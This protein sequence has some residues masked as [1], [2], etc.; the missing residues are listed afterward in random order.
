MWNCHWKI[1]ISLY[2]IISMAIEKL[3]EF[4]GGGSLEQLEKEVKELAREA[5]ELEEREN[6]ERQEGRLEEAQVTKRQRELK[7]QEQRQRLQ[8]IKHIRDRQL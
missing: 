6:K 4:V 5:V 7:L 3:K 2:K 1:K 8:E